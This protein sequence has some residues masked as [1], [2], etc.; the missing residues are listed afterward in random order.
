MFVYEYIDL[1]YMYECAYSYVCMYHHDHPNAFL[2]TKYYF[3][4]NN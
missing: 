1:I 4:A 2:S 3:L